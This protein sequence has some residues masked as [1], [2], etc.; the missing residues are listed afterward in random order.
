MDT[1]VKLVLFLRKM[2]PPAISKHDYMYIIQTDR[3]HTRSLDENKYMVRFW[4]ID[5][6]KHRW[7]NKPFGTFQPTSTYEVRLASGQWHLGLYNDGEHLI[8]VTLQ[9]TTVPDN[10]VLV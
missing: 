2:A 4:T 10:G 1:G 6:L 7:F 3:L 8:N 9:A 5:Y